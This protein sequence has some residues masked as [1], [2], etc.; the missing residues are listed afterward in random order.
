MYKTV[1]TN[2]FYL[3]F[4]NLFSKGV[5]FV[6]FIYV[7][8]IFGPENYGIFAVSIEY[9]GLF[10]VL[11]TFGFQMAIVREAS[12]S[13]IDVIEVVNK[14][15]P[16]RIVFSVIS[17]F[18]ALVIGFSIDGSVQKESKVIL[19]TLLVIILFQPFEDHIN[20]IFWAREEL[21]YIS[22]GEVVRVTFYVM[23]FIIFNVFLGLSLLNLV[24]A[25][26]IGFGACILFKFEILKRRYNFR[27]KCD[28]DY[29][30][31]RDIL[32]LSTSFGIVSLMYVYSLKID[33]QLLNSLSSSRNIGNYAASWQLV[34][35]GIIFIQALSTSL[36]PKSMKSMQSKDFR[37]SLLKN[38]SLLSL[39][40]SIL[41][42]SMWY[43]SEQIIYYIYGSKYQLSV[44]VFSILI[45]YLPIRLF[46]IWG[47]QVLESS[48]WYKL[49]ILIYLVPLITNLTLN[50]M[51]IP[52]YGAIA[53][54]YSLLVSNALL[55]TIITIV[56]FLSPVNA[57][58]NV[59]AR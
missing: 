1:L 31:L 19:A 4:S 41:C 22:L 2:V 51:Y 46:G 54:A 59:H 38:I 6:L 21:K 33:F 53:A 5:L 28:F 13:G 20:S 50:L 35:I 39:G 3:V 37:K 58:R 30:F 45:W 27:L 25:A 29:K 36:F 15:L 24:F 10:V 18:L 52:Q 16:L 32:P 12:R 7:A 56:A 48:D 26:I 40:F 47:S 14:L 57:S 55:I 11:V 23:F 8:R 34:N 43:F 17:F 49:R 9:V 42:F 44:Y